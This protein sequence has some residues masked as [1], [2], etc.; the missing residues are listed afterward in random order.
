[1]DWTSTG[2]NCIS[3]EEDSVSDRIRDISRKEG[4]MEPGVGGGVGVVQNV[5][6][7]GT[8]DCWDRLGSPVVVLFVYYESLKRELKT[9]LQH[10]VPGE[11]QERK[12][13][14]GDMEDPRKGIGVSQ[15]CGRST[16]CGSKL[17]LFTDPSWYCE[18]GRG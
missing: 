15:Y 18:D 14:V 12:S 17:E 16:V 1:M 3:V 2:Y 7:D 11:V 10:G 6:G 13:R 4:R 8:V 9:L 5:S